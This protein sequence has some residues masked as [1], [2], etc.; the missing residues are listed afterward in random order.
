M[1]KNR[2]T[3]RA[4]ARSSITLT[5]LALSPFSTV[6]A[7]EQTLLKPDGKSA[8]QKKKV[9]VFILMG[10]SNMVGQGNVDPTNTLGTLANI[11]KQQSKFPNLL[12]TNGNWSLRN[13][14]TYKG[15]VAATAAGPLTVGQGSGPGAIGP[16]LGFGQVMGFYFD[17]PVLVL[18][19]SE[20]GKDL[21]YQLLPPGSQRY[22]NSGY[23]YAGYGDSPRKW[24]VS[25]T[26][27]PDGT[28]GG[29]QYDKTVAAAKG[30][31]SNF[32][33]LYTNYAAQGY[34]IAGFAWF[35]GW[36]DIVD[37]V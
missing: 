20:G 5:A 14:A 13:D 26:P 16:E 27:V 24:L 2:M 33:T 6:S 28:Q 32:N 11:V 29:E 4:F 19:T 10:Q 23:I 7:A 9:K 37:S 15:V 17:E 12:D 3:R 34:V 21:G 22:T 30:V 25:S 8:D 35:Q 36:N 18:K 1:T 31:L